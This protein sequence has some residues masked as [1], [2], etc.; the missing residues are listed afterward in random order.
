MLENNLFVDILDFITRRS[1]TNST[2]QSFSPIQALVFDFAFESKTT[3]LAGSGSFL[4]GSFDKG[5][6]QT[7]VLFYA[8]VLDLGAD[9]SHALVNLSGELLRVSLL[10]F[11]G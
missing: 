9:L 5:T 2:I 10:Y 11:K 4:N 3:S 8:L 1:V 7:A 6:Q